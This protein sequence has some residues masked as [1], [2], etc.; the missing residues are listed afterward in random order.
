[1]RVNPLFTEEAAFADADHFV[2]ITYADL[3]G[4]GNTQTLPILTNYANATGVN[5]IGARLIT[6]F[7]S[8]DGTLVSTAFTIGDA[9][10]ATRYLA[11]TETNAAGSYITESVGA[12]SIP[13]IDTA[14]TVVNAYVTATAAKVLST[15]TAG[16][17][18]VFLQFKD[19]R[20]PQ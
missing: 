18:R 7:V 11:S 4:T 12:L 9:G 2:D 14:D 17:L 15:H 3:T 10:S 5:V 6:P 19:G 20:A 13:H 1:M 8:S 16:V